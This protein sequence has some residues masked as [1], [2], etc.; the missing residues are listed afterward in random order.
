MTFILTILAFIFLLG[1]IVLV[2]ELG[3]FIVAKS[4]GIYVHEF[5][6]GMGP[7]LFKKKGKETIYSLHLLPIGGFV[8]MAGEDVNSNSEADKE[9]SEDRL[10][11]NKKYWQKILVLIAGVTMNFIL[12]LLICSILVGISGHYVEPI[13]T[14]VTD[15][16][17]NYPAE[18]AGIQ[19]GDTITAITVSGQKFSV[20]NFNDMQIAHAAINTNE[21]VVY[22]IQRGEETLEIAVK[23]VYDEEEQRYMLGIY[24]SSEEII[25]VKWYTTPYYGT[26]YAI[27][28]F[29]TMIKS[30]KI[31][32]MP[33]GL[34]Q[35]SGP[36]GI[37]EVTGEVVS[38]GFLSYIA[39]IALLSMNVGFVN[40]LPLPVLDGGQVIIETI[41]VII[42]R[43]FSRK[44]KGII[45]AISWSVLV[46]LM[47]FVTIND[48]WKLFG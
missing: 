27:D 5:A 23:P 4:C 37:V 43:K 8:S 1:I 47:V 34:Q 19:V 48:I 33:N 20:S 26:R 45:M 10:F 13:P 30:L 6:I 11:C 28:Q 3:H 15:L 9:I 36:V 21:K 46:L 14:T 25:D 18:E 39:L 29:T 44:V 7:T 38:Y 22:T 42:R 41:Q 35:L 32:F 2:H 24:G 31:L 16:M 12:A 17:E 40:L